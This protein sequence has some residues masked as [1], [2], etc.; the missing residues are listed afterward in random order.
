MSM[1]SLLRIGWGAALLCLASTAPVPHRRQLAVAP[2]APP[3]LAPVAPDLGT[4]GNFVILTRTGASST[5]AS[6]ITGDMG[7]DITYAAVTGFDLTPVEYEHSTSSQIS[8]K[9][10]CADYGSGTK[11]MLTLAVHDMQLAYTHAATQPTS[12]TCGPTESAICSNVLLGQ[13]SGAV[14]KPGTYT[15]PSFVS[16]D[17]D[18]YLQ[19]GPDDIFIFQV[20]E[21]LNIAINAKMILIPALSG[22]T[23]TPKAEN[24]FWQTGTYMYVAPDAVLNGIFLVKTYASLAMG[25][26]LNG[27]LLAQTTVIL[28]GPNNITEAPP[29][30]ARGWS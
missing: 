9:A 29:N 10:Y 1:N 12:Y 18:I 5:P 15:W 25:I 28:G 21:Y 30:A 23:G 27:R 20:A 2:V 14:F 7:C 6:N 22:S 4:A 8:G 26:S 24:I 16:Y 11:N 19:G 3:D 13:I 17:S